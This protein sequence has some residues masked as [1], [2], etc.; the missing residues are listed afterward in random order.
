MI[1]ATHTVEAYWSELEK[2]AATVAELHA[3]RNRLGIVRTPVPK[4][5][6]RKSELAKAEGPQIA[7]L[8]R[9]LQEA[10][11]SKGTIPAMAISGGGAGA[12]PTGRMLRVHGMTQMKRNMAQAGLSATSAEGQRAIREIQQG[13]QEAV[14][15]PIYSRHGGMLIQSKGDTAQRIGKKLN[16]PAM[17]GEGR[18]ATNVMIGLHEGFERKAVGRPKE[19]VPGFGHLSPRVIMDET[20]LVK[21]MT[22]PGSD[23]ARALQA[24]MRSKAGETAALEHALKQVYGQRGVDYVKEHGYSKAMKKD[25][26]RRYASGELKFAPQPKESFL[27]KHLKRRQERIKQRKGRNEALRKR[28]I[29]AIPLTDTKEYKA[30]RAQQE[31]AHSAG[32]PPVDPRATAPVDRQL[33]AKSAVPPHLEKFRSRAPTSTLSKLQ[34]IAKKLALRR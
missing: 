28:G 2:I 24:A 31:R 1:L 27:Q 12:I 26:M 13:I 4:I 29:T 34:R 5:P 9:K 8:Q 17:S 30:L 15:Q 16:L 10:L 25:L 20:N 14:R 23:E 32:K 19:I 21:K 18:K 7:K 3:G 6:I 11:A 33:G 22:G